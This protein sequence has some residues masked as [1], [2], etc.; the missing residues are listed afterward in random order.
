MP[1]REGGIPEYCP[2]VRSGS[3]VSRY[4]LVADVGPAVSPGE[5]GAM[6]PPGEAGLRGEQGAIGPDGPPGPPGPTG[7]KG[8]RGA[9]GLVVSLSAAEPS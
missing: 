2:S 1:C 4:V 9:P 6:G 8:H 7:A 5:R 3:D